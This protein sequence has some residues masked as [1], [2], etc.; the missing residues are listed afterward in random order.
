LEGD[1]ETG[2]HTSAHKVALKSLSNWGLNAL[3]T[4]IYDYLFEVFFA[5]EIFKWQ[6]VK[7][8]EVHFVFHLYSISLSLKHYQQLVKCLY[9]NLG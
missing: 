8:Q 5:K 2:I 6:K 3:L 4:Y 7:G 9:K 1:P